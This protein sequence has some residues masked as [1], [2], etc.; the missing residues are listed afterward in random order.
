[1]EDDRPMSEIRTTHRPKTIIGWRE[2]LALP[3]LGI[4]AVKAKIDSGARTSALHVHFIEEFDDGPKKRVRFGIHPLRKRKDLELIC[5][6]DIVDFRRVKD[7]GG[8]S[9]MRHFIRT[10]ALLGGHRWPI[11]ISLT[12]REGMLFRML[13]GRTALEGKFIIDPGKSYVTGRS[14]SQKYKKQ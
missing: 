3:E 5:E 7:S 14:L 11:E 10:K 4:P 8:H 9:E 13:L 12:S 2:W 1:M 6:A